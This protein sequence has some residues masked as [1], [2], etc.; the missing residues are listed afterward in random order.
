MYQQERKIKLI[1]EFL[2]H[3]LRPSSRIKTINNKT[4]ITKSGKDWVSVLGLK[5]RSTSVS[6][7]PIGYYSQRLASF[8]HLIPV[9]MKAKPQNS[10]E[11]LTQLTGPNSI[12]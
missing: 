2:L 11:Q 9:V 5:L 6:M 7:E 1:R 8:H 12:F 10:Q 3:R 4:R